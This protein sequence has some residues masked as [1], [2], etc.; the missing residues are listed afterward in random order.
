VKVNVMEY[1]IATGSWPRKGAIDVD[2]HGIAWVSGRG[3]NRG[4][5]GEH[6][7]LLEVAGVTPDQDAAALAQA[8]WL[9]A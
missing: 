9:L 1:D 4:L 2:D 7:F 6:E 8:D 3:G 5:V